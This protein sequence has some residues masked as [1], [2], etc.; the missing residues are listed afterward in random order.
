MSTESEAAAANNEGNG[1][2]YS[3]AAAMKLYS[4]GEKIDNLQT[5]E[6]AIYLVNTY[7]RDF[8]SDVKAKLDIYTYR[9]LKSQQ[10]QRQQISSVHHYYHTEQEGQNL[11]SMVK[12]MHDTIKSII[13]NNTEGQRKNIDIKQPAATAEQQGDSAVKQNTT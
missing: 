1:N 9:I 5:M 13:Q 8:P 6:H 4:I 11:F 10:Q 3:Y 2:D 7:G 12:D